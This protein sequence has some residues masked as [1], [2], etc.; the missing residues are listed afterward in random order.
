MYICFSHR[1]SGWTVLAY[2]LRRAALM[3]PLLSLLLS[4]SNSSASTGRVAIVNPD[5]FRILK[6]GVMTNIGGDEN[7]QVYFSIP[8]G[9][10]P[11]GTAWIPTDISVW[12]GVGI[13]QD[14]IGS[15]LQ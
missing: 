13:Q 15:V 4:V 8:I 9:T 3:V 5:H 14:Y 6:A 7:R 12:E 11:D 1:R 10:V 2:G